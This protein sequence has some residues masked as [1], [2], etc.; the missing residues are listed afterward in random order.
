MA[1][2]HAFAPLLDAYLKRMAEMA[3]QIVEARRRGDGTELCRLV[4]RIRG[5]AGNYGFPTITDL[6]AACEMALR[7]PAKTPADAPLDKLVATLMAATQA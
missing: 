4:H 1:D 2:N 6:A 3:G 5:T 7:D